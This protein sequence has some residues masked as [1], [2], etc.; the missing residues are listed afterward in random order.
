MGGKGEPH[1]VTPVKRLSTA[2][3]APTPKSLN[4]GGAA[5]YEAGR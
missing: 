1:I 2:Q 3:T 5:V 4:V